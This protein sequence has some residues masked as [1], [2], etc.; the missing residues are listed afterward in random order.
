MT[1]SEHY[2][3]LLKFYRILI[4]TMASVKYKKGTFQHQTTVLQNLKSEC[5]LQEPCDRHMTAKL[6]GKTS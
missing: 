2:P 4:K 3:K 6:M 5:V 1:L